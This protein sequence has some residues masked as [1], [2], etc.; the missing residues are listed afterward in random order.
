ME[1]LV[2]KHVLNDSKKKI[3]Q[4]VTAYSKQK[5]CITDVFRG[6]FRTLLK[7]YDGFFL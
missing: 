5:L 1:L 2:K 4:S 3:I 6:V 7:F